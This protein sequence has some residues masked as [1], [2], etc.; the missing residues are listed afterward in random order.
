MKKLLPPGS[1]QVR[2][3]DRNIVTAFAFVEDTSESDQV[4]RWLLCGGDEAY[5][6]PPDA[7]LRVEWAAEPPWEGASLASWLSAARSRW[8]KGAEFIC[9]YYRSHSSEQLPEL[10]TNPLASPGYWGGGRATPLHPSAVRIRSMRG[11]SLQFDV[12]TSRVGSP[13]AP[14]W[15]YRFDPS[16]PGVSYEY[17]VLSRAHEANS[18]PFTAFGESEQP[19]T[20]ADFVASLN[21]RNIWR[22]SADTLALGACYHSDR[23]EDIR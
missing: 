4:Q 17:C 18:L 2:D 22:E 1:I 14:S 20:L 16:D 21:A 10:P 23:V 7:R 19:A 3:L 13:L 9:A 6:A 11:V 5:K 15:M 12:G 8:S